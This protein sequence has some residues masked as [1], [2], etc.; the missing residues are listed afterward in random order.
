MAGTTM[1][2]ALLINPLIKNIVCRRRPYM[3]HPEV[4][5]LKP[6]TA[7]SDIYDI[8]AQG[9]SFPSGHS[10]NA[11]AAYSML[12]VIRNRFWLRLIAVALPLLVAV[13]R[14]ALGVHYPTDVIAGLILG[15]GCAIGMTA[16]QKRV[17]RR[18]I[19]HAVIIAAALP[20]FFYCTT[21]DYFSFLGI[22]IGLFAAEAFEGKFVRFEN[23]Q[24]VIRKMLRLIGAVAIFFALNTLLKLPFSP[25]FL[26]SGTP[27]AHFVRTA[28]YAVVI[29][30]LIGI[31]PLLFRVTS[32]TG[33]N[34]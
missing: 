11:A 25:V 13:S 31:Y 10:Q 14:F 17:K 9:Y 18:W 4:R 1:A 28:R 2:V 19:M 3:D 34:K 16:L 27:L 15:Y 33:G 29:F 23:T 26:A 7:D 32:K 21:D 22:S 20:G 12:P 8:S 5:C 24:S 6:V 30:T